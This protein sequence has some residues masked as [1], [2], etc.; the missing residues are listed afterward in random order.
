MGGSTRF[1]LERYLDY[2]GELRC[3]L[4]G[5]AQSLLE[6]ERYIPGM[7]RSFWR[8]QL[9]SANYTERGIQ[10]KFESS[11]LTRHYS[12]IYGAV[13]RVDFPQAKVRAPQALTVQELVLLRNG[14]YRHAIADLAGNIWSVYALHFDFLENRVH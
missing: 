2:A 1:D 7:P 4:H 6:K 3:K 12:F 9:L 14:V 11:C 13:R 5:N 10:L 8:S